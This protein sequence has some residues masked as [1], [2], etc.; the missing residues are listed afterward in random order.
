[1]TQAWRVIVCSQFMKGEVEYALRS[2]SDK[3]D[4]IYNGVHAEKFNFNFP[5]EEAE[6]FRGQFAAPNEKIVMFVGRGVR[7]KGCQVLIDALP[8]VRMGYND[9]KLVIAGGGYRQHLVEQAR[10]LGIDR[11]VYFTGFIPDDALLRLFKVSDVACFPSLY[12]P[13]GIVA[14]EAMAAHTPVVVSDAGG[15]PEV[16]DADVTGTVTWANNSAS[17]AWGILRVLHNPGMANA[18]ADRAVE[19]VEAVFNWDVIA[20]QT[21][22]VYK[23]VYRE[24]IASS[25]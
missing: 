15:L 11:W 13:F 17:L 2:P 5:P 14:L 23:Q 7:E 18:M 4:V 16:V 12:E 10:A 9:T 3:L 1:M 24:Y 22:L 6:A 25:W 19:E 21:N 8:K 20:K